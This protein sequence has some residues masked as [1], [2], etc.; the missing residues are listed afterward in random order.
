MDPQQENLDMRTRDDERFVDFEASRYKPG[1]DY[2]TETFYSLLSVFAFTLLF[3]KSLNGV[4]SEIDLNHFTV[5]QVTLLFVL[6]LMLLVER[7]LYR[8][9]GDGALTKH[10]EAIRLAIYFM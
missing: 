6:L 8:G 1:R 5:G 3:W 9:R 10:R 7:M 2:F 4:S